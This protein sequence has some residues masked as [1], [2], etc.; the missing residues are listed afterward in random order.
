M[1]EDAKI[2]L[3]SILLPQECQEVAGK[4]AVESKEQCVQAHLEMHQMFFRQF[5]RVEGIPSSHA[6]K[7]K[8]KAVRWGFFT[9]QGLLHTV[10][11]NII[12]LV[13]S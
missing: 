2:F 12:S 8:I 9:F 7:I 3:E 6:T 5:G 10:V 11:V 1:P 13:L 4:H